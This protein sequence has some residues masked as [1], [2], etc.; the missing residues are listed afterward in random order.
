M[1]YYLGVLLLIL[2][3]G[4]FAQEEKS[5]L[6]EISGNNLKESSYLYGTMHVSQKIAFR[7]DDVFYEA[8]YKS[9]IVALESDPDSWLEEYGKIR[10]SG[11]GY[12]TGFV[13]KGFYIYPFTF[14]NPTKEIVSSYLSLD[15]RLV[16][17]ILYRTNESSQNFE[18]E[19]YLDMYIYQAGKKFSKP[20]EALEDL[21]ES[22]ALVGRAN[23]NAMKP[24]PDEWLQKKMQTQDVM[25]LLQDAYRERNIN[26]IDSLD[27]AMYT[28]YYLQN[29]LY[30]R[31]KN[32]ARR[33]DSLMHTAK[34]FAGIGAAHLPG[35]K[36]V[37][38]LLRNMGYQV[39]PL[40]SR[41]SSKGRALKDS[42]E[43]KILSNE[44]G[45]RTPDDGLFTILLPNQLYPIAEYTNTTYISPD[46]ANGSYLMVNRIPT[47]SHLKKDYTFSLDD[48][49]K[50]LFENIPGKILE[51]RKIENGIYPGLDIKN[52]LKNGDFQRY[53]IY[54]TP[55]EILMFKMSGQGDYVVKH[56]D[57]IF[58]SIS[59]K[60][61][62]KKRTVLF[63][64]FDDFEIEMPTIYNFTNRNR[65][66]NRFIEGVHSDTPSYNFL[67]KA[68]LNDFNFIEADTFELK[69]IQ[70]RFYQD[71][72]LKP[73]YHPF[74]GQSL[75][76]SAKFGPK[77]LQKLYLK[78]IIQEN[79]YYLLGSLTNDSTDAKQFF[80]SFKI[81]QPKYTEEFKKVLDTALFFSTISPIDPPKFVENSNNY[82]ER[83][84]KPKPYSAYTK[85]SVYQNKNNEAILVTVNKAHDFLMFPNIDSVW[86]LRRKLY[87]QNTFN[88][89]REDR[90]KYNEKYHEIN[91]TLTDTASTRG[92]MIKNIVKG[93]LLYEVKAL[94]DTVITPSKFVTDFFNNFEPND[95]LIGSSILSDKT[96]AFFKAIRQNDSIVH[97]GFAFLKF[98]KKHSDSLKY[99]ISEFDF[100]DNQKYLQAYL[101]QKLAEMPDIDATRFFESYYTRSYNNSKAQTK[102][103]QA[104]SKKQDESSLELLLRLMSTD[105]PLV[106]SKQEIQNIFQPYLDSLP[107]ANLLFPEIL[108][109][110]AIEEYKSPIFSMLAKLKARGFIK[111]KSYKKYKNQIL[112]DAKIQL[113]R[114]LS[115]SMDLLNEE[116]TISPRDNNYDILENYAVLLYP[117]I[118]E[119][120][121]AMFF[122]RL[123]TVNDPQI[124]SS[125]IALLLKNEENPFGGENKIPKSLII[126]LAEN[127]ETRLLL[128]EKLK[129][130]GKSN[131]F[132]SQYRNQQDI[133]ESILY[134]NLELN[135]EQHAITFVKDLKMYYPTMG[136]HA[137]FFKVRDKDNYS[138]NL[139]MYM[140][141][142]K[143][144]NRVQSEPYYINKGFNIADINTE[145]EVLQLTTEEYNL[146]DRQRA[147]V[148]NPSTYTGF[149]H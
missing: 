83:H 52:Q 53:H 94:I 22:S 141:V 71:L 116:S 119:T 75:T 46:L 127:P 17:N 135:P 87:R 33:L 29:M 31:N 69:Q 122:N 117:F 28:E 77:G 9:E 108:D 121:V 90:P 57:T 24:K 13:T 35:K 19:T 11:I 72:K 103:L 49:D 81:K 97:D 32:M 18:E 111:P 98:N 124:Q 51:K 139:K 58:N 47:F 86:Q 30:A 92:I 61:L 25:S 76:S 15:D 79:N 130:I 41:F 26:L 82:Y 3:N 146:K 23:M 68:T 96:S 110:S 48:V 50:L 106:S 107:L 44:Y 40:T 14:K 113:K 137:Y 104:I 101:I 136:H 16:N 143:N 84:K 10:S 27:Q 126:S 39:K 67:K 73:E 37:I 56:S 144:T 134:K 128:F 6:W 12:G 91:L 80:D 149:I 59:F 95:T 120:E 138:N 100:K 99:Y 38:H 45:S 89:I 129:R 105:L 123:S 63:S 20:I 66:G 21:E 2:S 1:R 62:E 93:G 34:V 78:T 115:L 65:K 54:I 8:L 109:Y 5:L 112:N 42:L 102:I 133:A 4:I 7:L 43:T 36:G 55:L 140:L 132:P 118:K 147:I 60:A 148:N 85:K 145:E 142:F 131:F 74:D 70:S 125:Y 114:Q 64:D 88:I